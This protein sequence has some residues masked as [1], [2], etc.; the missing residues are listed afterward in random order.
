MSLMFCRQEKA[1]HPY[2]VDVLGLNIYT[3]QE[4]CYVI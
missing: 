4:L 1:V 3:S 2:Y